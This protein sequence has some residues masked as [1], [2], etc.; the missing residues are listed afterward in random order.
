[1]EETEAAVRPDVGGGVDTARR[2]A[3]NSLSPLL[4][5]LLTKGI[6][7]LYGLI[8]IRLLGDR[9]NGNYALA[10][11]IWLYASTVSNWGLDVLLIRDVARDHTQA[12]RY[13][14]HTLLL[15]L[16][17]ALLLLPLLALLLLPNPGLLLGKDL[18]DSGETVLTIFLLALS[19]LPAAVAAAATSVFQAFERMQ[20][21]A[22]VTVATAV[23]KFGLGIGA[24]GLV[25]LSTGQRHQPLM[26]IVLAAVPLLVNSFTATVLYRLMRRSLLKPRLEWDRRFAFGLLVVALPLLLNS[27]LV[28]L[29][30]KFDVFIL[31]ANYPAEVLG[32]YDAAY[33]FINFFPLIT[34]NLTFAVFPIFS[35][36]ANDA[37]AL[38][39]AYAKTLKLLLL[40]AMPTVAGTL[41]LASTVVWLMAGPAFLPEGGQALQILILFLPLS[42]FSGLS[43]YVL[44]ALG[45]QRRITQAFVLVTVFN[46]GAN[47][48]LIPAFSLYA[49]SWVTVASEVVLSVP[50]Y[51]LLRRALGAAMPN[52]LALTLRPTLA[53]VVVGTVVWLTLS[54]GLPGL[55]AAAAGGLVYI[56]LL[57]VL[58]TFSPDELDL[59]RR[60]LHR[61]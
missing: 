6:D 34:A 1:V 13:F 14:S 15:R 12:N 51:L 57:F 3:R 29:F 54:L 59:L 33:K 36:R 24:L 16:G 49:A 45:Q 31:R 27:L 9:L 22:V 30:F 7:T 2:V 52:V 53:A 17:L 5:Q 37:A 4:A 43:Q 44:I 48:L 19:L 20:V 21:P 39:R 10:V 55:V 46:I 25:W 41:F 56:P 42:F 28:N 8:V 61:K 26:L 35:R 58:R 50:I 38:G 23:V 40:I 32:K 47:L 18:Q 11:G 60:A